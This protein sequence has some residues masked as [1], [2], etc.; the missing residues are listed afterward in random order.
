M[1]STTA[2]QPVAP[3]IAAPALS[4]LTTVSLLVSDALALSL[5]VALSVAIKAAFDHRVDVP[6]YLRLWPFLLV[7]LAVYAAVGLYSVVAL[8]PPEELRRGTV[9]STVLFLALAAFT[10]SFR[11]DHSHAFTGTLLAAIAISIALMPIMR[12]ST[13]QICSRASWWGY[14]AVIFGSRAS[15]HSV[16]HALL[17][18]PGLGLRPVAVLDDHIPSDEIHGI[19]VVRSFLLPA[20]A[21]Q[22][23]GPSYAVITGTGGR[24]APVAKIVERYGRYFS[25]VIVIPELEGFSAAWADPRSLGG[26][27]GLEISRN[28]LLRERP[29]AKRVLD[30]VLGIFAA[31]VA[32]PVCALIAAAIRLDSRG[33][34]F[35][36][37]ERIGRDGRRFRAWKF[38]T[39]V[40]N[41]A[42]VLS[43]HLSANPQLRAE[44]ERDQKLRHDPRVTRVGRFLRAMSL[45]ELPQLWNVLCREMSLVGPRPIV[46]SE[47]A[48]YGDS[49]DVYKR[50]RGG[51]TGLWQVSGR[52]DT[53]Y[54]ERVYLD[55]WYVRNWSVW[56]DLCILFRTIAVVLF[57]KGAY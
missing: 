31:L 21:N 34:V 14:P 22:L 39:M 1:A 41:A 50:V 12:E 18:E 29:F 10:I 16:L 13:R 43:A 36:G 20:I 7:F 46:D 26:M 9:S 3:A 53:T 11:G 2:V 52:S 49:F 23:Q 44:W 47:V 48:R 30:L 55:S 28:A 51:I 15:G 27:V 32:A 45:D 8:S 25:H 6:S 5:S 24:R 17:S 56:L 40:P 19:P 4:W 57:R 35:F 38:R 37:Q 54:A 33:P 42:E